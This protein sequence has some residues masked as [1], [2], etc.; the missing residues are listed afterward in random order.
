M[1]EKSTLNTGPGSN[2]SPP[3]AAPQTSGDSYGGIKEKFLGLEDSL[4][5]LK[6][7]LFGVDPITQPNGQPAIELPKDTPNNIEDPMSRRKRLQIQEAR[8]SVFQ[9]A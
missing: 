5:A 7:H 8:D 4:K 6:Q 2:G 1:F 3:N 9:K